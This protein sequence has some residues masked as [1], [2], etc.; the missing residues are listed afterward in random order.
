MRNKKKLVAH[1]LKV[2][3]K[4]RFKRIGINYDV[5]ER[6]IIAVDKNT[7]RRACN[8]VAYEHQ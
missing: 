2:F 4:Y 1:V 6:C 3:S 5:I 8:K 7:V